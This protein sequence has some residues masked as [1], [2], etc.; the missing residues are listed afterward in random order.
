MRFLTYGITVIFT[1]DHRGSV[2][3]IR[4]TW[5]DAEWK[6]ND[7]TETLLNEK[8]KTRIHENIYLGECH[9]QFKETL[10]NK[11]C[12][13]IEEC[14][15]KHDRNKVYRIITRTWQRRLRV[16]LLPRRVSEKHSR[17]WRMFK[18]HWRSR[19]KKMPYHQ[20]FWNHAEGKPVTDFQSPIYNMIW[21]NN[22]MAQTPIF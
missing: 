13:V 6:W 2:T 19:L 17:N 8:V 22:K 10:E 11:K 3:I 1:E 15:R 20:N 7:H 14:H 9:F 12:Q 16:N 4:I 21:E 5:R 18:Q